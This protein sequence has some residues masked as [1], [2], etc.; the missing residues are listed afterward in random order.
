MNQNNPRTA[1]LELFFQRTARDARKE[2][3]L[4]QLPEKKN[5]SDNPETAVLS[6]NSEGRQERNIF[7]PAS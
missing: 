3:S 7:K 6:T 4:G 1:A 5:C 2:T